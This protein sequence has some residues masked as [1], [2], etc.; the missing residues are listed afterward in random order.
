MARSEVAVELVTL[1]GG[2]VVDVAVLRRLLDLESRG[3]QFRLEPE[4]HF[5]VIPPDKLTAD[6]VAFLRARR[7]EAR[8]LIAYDADVQPQA[9]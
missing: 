3:C 1:R 2:L 7:D 4:G 8:R 6:D 9:Q 5:R